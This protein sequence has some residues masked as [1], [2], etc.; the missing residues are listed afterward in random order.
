MK[1]RMG[2]LWMFCCTLLIAVS[3]CSRKKPEAGL[4]LHPERLRCEFLSNPEGVDALNPRLSWSL[5][6]AGRGQIQTAYR[7]LASSSKDSLG[8]D[9]GDLWDS[10]RVLSGQSFD[11]RYAGRKLRPGEACC[12]KVRVWDKDGLE[13]E[14]SESGFWRAGLL[15]P[16]G[17]KASW[18]GLDRAVGKDDPKST[19]TRCSARMLR[20]EFDISK[21]VKQAVAFYCGLGLSELTLNGK[22]VG[23][24]VLSPGLTDYDKTVFYIT[25]DVTPLI[26]QGKNA[27]GVMLGNG[28]YFAP[29]HD[30]HVSAMRFPK[31]LFQLR[32]E[33]QDGTV[34]EVL[35]DENWKV[36]ADGPITANNEF[37]GE[38][39]DGRKE[40]GD[41]NLP[42]FDDSKW[43]K[44]EK[45][46]GPAG[47]LEAQ[48]IAPIRVTRSI[49]P[50]GMTHPKPNVTVY[51]MGQNMVGWVRLRVKGGKPGTVVRLR[52]AETLRKDGML[53]TANL[54]SARAEDVFILRGDSVE[55]YEP[56]FT[57]H[58]FRYVE[59]TGIPGAPD[60]GAVEGRVVHDDVETAGTFS[61]SNNLINKIFGNVVWGVRGNYRSMPTDC[62]QRDE[63]QGW[64]G[65]R[66]IGSKGESFLFDIHALYRKWMNDIRDAQNEAGSIPDVVP[67]FWKIYN[68]NT[69]WAGTYVILADMLC[70]QYGDSDIVRIHYPHM[71]KWMIYMTKYLKDGLMTK[72]TYGDWCVPPE[73][74]VLIHSQDPRRTTPAELIGTAYFYHEARL[75]QKFAGMMA[76]PEDGKTFGDMADRLKSA[77]NEKLYD[78]IKVQYA[79]HSATSNLLPLAFDMVPDSAR[80]RVFGNIVEKIMGDADGHTVVGLVGAQ[81]IMRMLDRYGRSDIAVR[82]SENNT[83]PSWG[84]MVE[85]GAT[86]VWE[87]WNGNTADP[88]MNSGN[89]VMLVG[90]LIIWL[91]ENIAGIRSDPSRPGFKHILMK[92]EPSGDLTF[93]NASYR[94]AYGLIQSEWGIQSGRFFWNVVIPPNSDATVTLPAKDGKSVKE[95]GRQADKAEGVRFLRMEEGRAVYAVGSGSYAFSVDAFQPTAAHQPYAATPRILPGDTSAVSPSKVQIRMQ[96]ATEGVQIRYTLDGSEPTERSPLYDQPLETD[97]YAVVTARAFKPGMAPSFRRTAVID[98]S[99]PRINGLNYGYYE[100]KWDALPDFAGL[101]PVKKGSVQ[102]FD[103]SKIK[104]RADYFG[105]VFRGFLRVPADGEYTFS[106]ASDDGS[107][108]VIDGKSVAVN[109]S[110]HA[111]TEKSGT[112]R[113]TAGR[114]AVRIEFFDALNIDALTLAVQGPGL[115]RQPVPTSFLFKK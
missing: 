67:T 87:L 62:P 14:W 96:C 10:G 22:K 112:V 105:V 5:R 35:S 32:I 8:S 81:W 18:I 80:T 52:F 76:L 51:D 113:L 82:L 39:C 17:W 3:G 34:Q 53:Y 33:F 54:R 4:L 57:Y 55:T 37:D 109:D 6:S 104:R 68:D 19:L 93:V 43:M 72:D 26:R 85:N 25:H 56:R 111:M 23:D 64:L 42:G 103:F 16:S 40:I 92:P 7:I 15:D 75:M 27:A 88:A 12:W 47:K 79:N 108:L 30:E 60:P 84:Y 95:A 65:D 107:R 110:V 9:C 78:K 100:G 28:R 2:I 71:K 44:A 98:V 101:K 102:G 20:T 41:W 106:I 99:D 69:T 48:P 13:S 21:K 38:V 77:M 86:T 61:C 89:H 66:A 29:R 59:A 11:V 49:R 90:D 114:H 58:G 45:V 83:Y 24:E 94:S 70:T 73:S 115:P 97:K 36:T 1:R 74:P 31:L 46:Q 63:R 50:V 91:Y